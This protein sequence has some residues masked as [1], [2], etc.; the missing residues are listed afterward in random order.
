M[1]V[2]PHACDK[3][4]CALCVKHK[5]CR[6]RHKNVSGEL[7]NTYF[8]RNIFSVSKTYQ[9]CKILDIRMNCHRSDNYPEAPIDARL[10]VESEVDSDNEA[11]D[12]TCRRRDKNT[13]FTE[14]LNNTIKTKS[15]YKS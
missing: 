12:L 10:K 1:P 8:H 15:Y 5:C 11:I 3:D 9:I 6:S 4:V 7:L 2:N 13:F 14:Q